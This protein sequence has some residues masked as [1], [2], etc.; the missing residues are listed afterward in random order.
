ML[1]CSGGSD[2]NEADPA[3]NVP[4]GVITKVNENVSTYENAEHGFAFEFPAYWNRTSDESSS[5]FYTLPSSISSID[6]G[7]LSK[8]KLKPAAAK[9]V[10]NIV[11]EIMPTASLTTPTFEVRT[12]KVG[13]HLDPET[14]QVRNNTAEEFG[15]EQ[16]QIVESIL[17]PSSSITNQIAT[18]IAGKT[19]A[20]RL[21]YITSVGGKQSTFNIE[22]FVID[23]EGK[24]YKLH[25]SISPLNVPEMMP[26]FEKILQSFRFI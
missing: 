16:S 1:L 25:F 7:L 3:A 13:S 19:D 10:S 9:N 21:D 17:S 4:S 24:L 26:E 18:T 11:K 5:S 23:D 15:R 2:G 8:V 14:L 6:P 20:W 12:Y 22:G